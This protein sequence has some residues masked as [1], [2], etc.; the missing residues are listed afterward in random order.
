MSI[1]FVIV[2]LLIY[3][4]MSLYA[5]YVSFTRI[6]KRRDRG[7]EYLHRTWESTHTFLIL[8]VNYFVWLY[9]SAVADVAREVAVY[10]VLFGFVF[11]I[12]MALYL[13]LFYIKTDVDPNHI[14]DRLFAWSNVLLNVLVVLI[15]V[16]TW[17][18][19]SSGEYVPNDILAHLLLP[20][21]FLI[22]PLVAVPLYFLYSTNVKK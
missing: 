5:T 21:I 12:R 8:S 18:V 1:W 7:G 17:Q 15:G 2:P 3:L 19:V 10:A 13:K 9:S 20:G 6:G 16:E 14:L 4:P 22:I 11:I